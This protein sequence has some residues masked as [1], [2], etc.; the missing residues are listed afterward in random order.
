MTNEPSVGINESLFHIFTWGGVLRACT[1]KV[2]RPGCQSNV[3]DK[4]IG[5]DCRGDINSVFK[6]KYWKKE[7]GATFTVAP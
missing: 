3:D 5:S 7:A 1:Y 4:I 6:E 2:G